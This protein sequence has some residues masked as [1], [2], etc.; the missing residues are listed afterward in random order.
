MEQALAEERIESI[1]KG[2]L[3]RIARD[4]FQKG[5]RAA[6]AKASIEELH[7][8]RISAKKFRYTLELFACIYAAPLARL[9][10]QMKRTQALL[11]DIND[12]ATVQ[13][14]ILGANGA[15]RIEQWL[16][17]RRQKRTEEFC[18]YWGEQFGAPEMAPR[19]IEHLSHPAAET[20]IL[21]KPVKSAGTKLRS[22]ERAQWAVA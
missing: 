11:G 12:I 19:W 2:E 7:N 9:Q 8:F 10:E 20:R 1:A 17:K 6:G 22:S 21:K 5:K 3:P 18:R 14:M 4:F 15:H 16:E 13:Q